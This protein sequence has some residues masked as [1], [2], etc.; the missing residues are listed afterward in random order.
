MSNVV[1]E[2]LIIF[3]LALANGIFAMSEIAMVSARPT[4]LKERAKGG[5]RGAQAALDTTQDLNRFLST[6]QIGITLIGIFA[7]AFGGTTLARK[8]A[9]GMDD[10][11]VLAPYSQGLGVVIVVLGTTY[12][13][14]VVGELVPKR[15]ALSAAEDIA[16]RVARPMG[17]IAKAARPAVSLLSASTEAV[18][19]ILPYNGSDEPPVTEDEIRLLLEQGT[20]A[21]IIEQAE[22]DIVDRTLRLDDFEVD[23]IMTPAT[24]IKWLDIEDDDGTFLRKAIAGGRTRYPVC[25]EHLDDVVGAV[26]VRDLF[27]Q[28]LKENGEEIDFESILFEP[29]FVVENTPALTVLELFRSHRTHLALVLD[30]FGAVEGLVTMH[31]ILEEIVGDVPAYR[32]GEESYAVQ[33]EDGSW[34]LDGMLPLIDFRE[35]FSLPEFPQEEKGD[36]HTLAGFVVKRLGHIPTAS[37]SFTWG[38][39]KFEVVDMDANRV[40][41]VLVVPPPSESDQG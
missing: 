7:G 17:F 33:R 36:Y 20:Q 1:T 10:I 23:A 22:Q 9:V 15:I 32:E 5:E 37:E 16:V 12:L 39:F 6:I 38:N 19:G 25:R 27:S 4:R 34:L 11:P 13:T 29:V 28:V 40:D 30:E 3:L 21:G 8:I 2:L 31:D 24:K 41:K 35:L 18:M 14:L 26:R